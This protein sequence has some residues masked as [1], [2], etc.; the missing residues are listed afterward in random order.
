MKLAE[1]GICM[2]CALCL[3][4]AA[5]TQTSV[6]VLG[7]MHY[8]DPSHHDYAW[9]RAEGLDLEKEI[10]NYSR[11]TEQNLPVL[12]EAVRSTVAHASPAVSY[13]LQAGDFTEG[14]CGSRELATEQLSAFVGAIGAADLGVPFLPLR[15]N[16]DV[17]GPG[18]K[19]ALAEVIDPWVTSQLGVAVE[20]GCYT[21]VQDDVRFMF[22]NRFDDGALEWLEEALRASQAAEHVVLFH[23][24]V[25]PF[26]ARSTWIQ[27][28]TE[29]RKAE[30]E[31]LLSLLGEFNAIVLCAHVH[32]YGVVAR[33]TEERGTFVQV[34]L[35]SV[36]GR[37]EPEARNELVGLEDYG[38]KLTDLRPTFDPA[39]LARRKQVLEAE[40]PFI[41]HF[42]YADFPGYGRLIFGEGQALLEVYVGASSEPWRTIDLSALRQARP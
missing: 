25:V 40:K 31:R 19:E 34:C 35:N 7:D 23:E 5:G 26:T 32:A 24:P 20:H 9:L 16:H 10:E 36:L 3:A 29:R 21:F 38:E 12:L 4:G 8:D 14:L 17:H 15:G 33:K 1:I 39:S 27:F 37:P 42:E 11:I 6:V 13:V 41:T 2:A 30:R 18:A 22:F 28:P